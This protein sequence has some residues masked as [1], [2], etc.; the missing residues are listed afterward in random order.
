V[1]IN[2]YSH[3]LMA[4]A[5]RIVK[6]QYPN[7]VQV[8]NIGT[9]SKGLAFEAEDVDQW[10]FVFTDIDGSETITLDFSRGKFDKAVREAKPW[11]KTQ[12][13]ELPR[14]MPLKD[15]FSYL[16]GAG[17]KDPVRS[18]TLR[19]PFPSEKAA[20]YVFKTD[21]RTIYMDAL[22]GEIKIVVNES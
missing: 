9:S 8:E 15:A 6:P 10:Q 3:E 16:R 22:G 7:A 5:E 13:K 14:N 19:A 20:T 4:D 11:I 1:G 17:F 12:I 2:I 21:K 18:V